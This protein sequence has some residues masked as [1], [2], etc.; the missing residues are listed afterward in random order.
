MPERLRNKIR[1]LHQHGVEAYERGDYDVALSLLK[2]LDA[3]SPRMADVLNR[4]GII[5][6]MNDDLKSAVEYLQRAVALNPTYT[7]AAL[8]LT[9]TYNEL[10][11]TDK[12]YEIF[13]RLSTAGNLKEGELDPYAAGKIANEHY[14]VGKIYLQFNRLDDAIH[15]FRKAL[16]LR[17]GLADVQARLGTA[18]R[19]NGDAEGAVTVLEEAVETNPKYG[20]AWIQLGLA[21]YS[22]GNHPQAL[23]TWQRALKEIP[24]LKEAATLLKLYE[25]EE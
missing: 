2:E 8:N 18:L 13:N 6:N 12:A 1:E 15:E 14:R 24:D 5:C 22:L 23:D 10:G 9:I 7:E 21:Y 11:E 25:Q 17:S 3:I 19:E 4:L 20:A 16:K